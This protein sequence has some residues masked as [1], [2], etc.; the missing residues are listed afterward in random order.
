MGCGSKLKGWGQDIVDTV[1]DPIGSA[2][3]LLHEIGDFLQHDVLGLPTDEELR[4]LSNDGILLNKSSNINKRPVVYGRRLM[5]GSRVFVGVSGDNNNYLH[6]VLDI[7]EGEIEAIDDVYIDDVISTDARFNGHVDIYKYTGTTTQAADSVLVSAFPDWTTA[8]QLKGIAYVHCRFLYNQDVFSSFPRITCDIRGKKV[9]DPRTSTTAYSTNPALCLRD[10]LTSSIYGKELSASDID[11]NAIISA[12]NYCETQMTE[13]SG[14]GNINYFDCNGVIRTDKR[15]IDNANILSNSFRSYLP[16]ISG[17]FSSFIEK[18]ETANFDF[19]QD[20][21]IDGS[22]N[23]AGTSK[24]DKLNVIKASYTSIPKNWQADIVTQEVASYLTDDNNIRLERTISLPFETNEYRARWRAETAIK[25]SREGIAVSF[26]ATI[27]ALRVEVGDVV[28]ITH[29][30]PGW[31][32]KKFRVSTVRIHSSGTLSFS[33]VEHEPT[34]YDR[35]VPAGSVTPPDTSLPDPFTVQPPSNLQAT[36]GTNQLL[37]SGDGSIVSRVKLTWSVAPDLYVS[38][39][40]IQYKKTSDSAWLDSIPAVGQ[41][42]NEA[43]ILGVV[44][45]VAYDI[46]I[47][48]VNSRNVSSA[49][50]SI[51]HTVIGK[52]QAPPDVDEF[53]IQEQNDGTRQFSWS[54]DKPVDHG[55][56]KIRYSQGSGGTWATMVPL[57][58][59][60]ILS[61]P[62]ETNLLL[63]GSYTFGIK[64]VDTTGNESV[65]ALYIEAALGDPRLTESIDLINFKSLT[66][67]G[68][69]TDCFINE[70]NE[71]ESTNEGDW[72]SNATWDDWTE[73]RQGT[74]STIIYQ[75]TTYDVG[76]Q[77]TFKPVV[78]VQADGF[79]TIEEQH[80]DDDITYSAWANADGSEI[81]TRYIRIRITVVNAL[82]PKIIDASLNISAKPIL[83]VVEDLDTST[84]TGANREEAGHI[85]IPLT[86][87]FNVIKGVTVTLQSV[88]AGWSVVLESKTDLTNG[89]EVKIY[90]ASNSLDDATIDAII[91]GA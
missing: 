82:G 59:D 55:G 12:A 1:T 73:W 57:H 79:V 40:R 60:L 4:E 38:H 11:D 51:Q 48:A 21:I 6:V 74:H 49:A 35:T 2:V 26:N 56:Y 23:F 65:N 36:S 58:D 39:Y 83:Q 34:V 33:L 81:T 29:P 68:T 22:W 10:Y 42:A 25:K 52:T 41:S 88:A 77:A 84:L 44:D 3:D 72:T 15:L 19:N 7:C 91:R 90:D 64:A 67:P 80:S 86:K 30:T 75:H 45:G 16:Y 69:K 70:N 54:Y 17:K 62:W 24:K 89:P 5:G 9:Y 13:Y 85:R 37:L 31:V 87:D 32:A 20:N 28:T 61:S 50:V 8:H 14:G 76:K 71:L 43:Y 27:A 66:W 46:R 53:F 63:A 78:N 18:D 47:I